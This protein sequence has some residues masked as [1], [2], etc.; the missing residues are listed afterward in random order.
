MTSMLVN[1]GFAPQPAI[2]ASI[3]F[4]ER[5]LLEQ[6]D[7][8]ELAKK[9]LTKNQFSCLGKLLGKES[10]WNPLAKNPKSSAKGIG[11]LLDSTY[12]NLG[13]K[14]SEAAVPQLVGT[15]AYI[16]RRHLSVCSAYR[17]FL[18]FNYY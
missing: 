8:K 4:K 13:M 7:A 16:H 5:P 17:H 6:V 15:L 12:E 2:P 3:I 18:R 11:Q 9:L 10:A 1:A 14:H